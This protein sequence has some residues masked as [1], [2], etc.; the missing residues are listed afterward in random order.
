MDY[1]RKGGGMQIRMNGEM[2]EVGTQAGTVAALLAAL[3]VDVRQVAVERNGAIV[4]K[5][6]HATTVIC[7]G[8]SIELVTFVGG[9]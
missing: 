8:D 5:S 6:L 4:P 3:A 7:E 9:G 2:Q 1:S